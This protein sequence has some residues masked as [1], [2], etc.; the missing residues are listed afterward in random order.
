MP[1]FKKKSLHYKLSPKNRL[2]IPSLHQIHPFR[3]PCDLQR[4]V[5][6]PGA[7]VHGDRLHDPAAQ[8]PKGTSASEKT[9]ADKPE[10]A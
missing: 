1:Y 4:H 5:I 7:V 2:P 8:V 9:K 6:F 10:M 3:Q